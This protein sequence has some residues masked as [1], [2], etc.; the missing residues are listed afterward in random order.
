MG[1][2][3]FSGGRAGG[4]SPMAIAPGDP[5]PVKWTLIREQKLGEGYVAEICYPDC[6]N[7]EGRKILVYRAR[8]LNQIK[9]ANRGMLDP[10]FSDD[11]K[12]L[13]PVARFEPTERGWKLALSCARDL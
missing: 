3:L 2:R 13:S 12:V 4:C 8:N 6:L 11:P 7:F 1:I 5:N 10:H 9:Q